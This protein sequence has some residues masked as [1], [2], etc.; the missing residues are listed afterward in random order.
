MPRGIKYEYKR[1]KRSWNKSR[2]H[3]DQNMDQQDQSFIA[4]RNK[5]NDYNVKLN[6]R[7]GGKKIMIRITNNERSGTNFL[8]LRNKLSVKKGLSPWKKSQL[9]GEQIIEPSGTN[10][11]VSWN[12]L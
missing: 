7:Q 9:H 5:N 3:G 2:L 4:L 1:N 6:L 12:K 11:Q 8:D 10:F